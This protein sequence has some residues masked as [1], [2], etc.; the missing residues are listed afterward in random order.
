MD[1]K[2]ILIGVLCVGVAI[3][4]YSIYNRSAPPTQMTLHPSQKLQVSK[5]NTPKQ[6]R[7]M[8]P[9]NVP[10]SSARGQTARRVRR[11]SGARASIPSYD[12]HIDT[13]RASPQ[14]LFPQRGSSQPQNVSELLGAQHTYEAYS[15]ANARGR[16]GFLRQAN[17]RPGF[18]RLGV[19]VHSGRSNRSMQG[20]KQQM[21]QAG[22]MRAVANK[23]MIPL[24]ELFLDKLPEPQP[25]V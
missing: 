15:Q 21:Q 20:I 12:Q 10:I 4:G 8:R 17:D 19:R 24:P 9:P 7:L 2:D 18:G 1:S 16:T 25:C 3:L 14:T 22:D 11:A 5:K 6:V 23:M 13:G